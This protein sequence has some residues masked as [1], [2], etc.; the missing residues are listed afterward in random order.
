MLH[1]PTA[2]RICACN[3]W[4]Q[5]AAPLHC[6]SLGKCLVALLSTSLAHCANFFVYF[7]R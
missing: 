1:S 7:A 6:W 5:L 4:S 2:P 3:L